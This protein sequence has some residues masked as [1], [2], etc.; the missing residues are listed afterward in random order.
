MITYDSD[1]WPQSQVL[2]GGGWMGSAL[3]LLLPLPLLSHDCQ[4]TTNTDQSQ[5]SSESQSALSLVGDN[6]ESQRSVVI[7]W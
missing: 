1:P 5:P 4:N 3:E 7:G 2:V 6:I